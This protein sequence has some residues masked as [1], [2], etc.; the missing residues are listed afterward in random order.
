[1]KHVSMTIY[2]IYILL[3]FRSCLAQTYPLWGKLKPGPNGV[4]F[5]LI[6]VY[7]YSRFFN[8]ND[9]LPVHE[10]ISESARPIRVYLWYPAQK[11][12]VS[13]LSFQSFLRMAA[14]N[15]HPLDS[16]IEDDLE[17]LP[18]PVQLEKG[19]N[20]ESLKQLIS[21]TTASVQNAA[22]Q[23]GLF[24]LIVFGQGLYYESPLTHLV[25]CEYLASHGY[26]VATCPLM[27]THY[28]LVNLNVV[29]LETQ[30]RDMEF[31]ISRARALPFVHPH[32]LGVIGYDMGGMAG[33]TLSMRNPEV[34]AFVSLDAGI[35]F[36]HPSALPNNHP[37]YS[38]EKFQ[39]P[40]MHMT[41]ARFLSFARSQGAVSSS[42][43]RKQYGDSYLFLVNTESHGDFTSYSM[44]GIEN[45]V[46]AY[47]GP[48]EKDPQPLYEAI[49]RYCLFFLDGYIKGNQKSLSRLQEN[50][51]DHGL[52]DI[53]VAIERKKGDEPP[54][55]KDDLVN[56]IIRQGTAEAMP[57][58][59]KFRA[60]Y[61]DSLLF[62]ENVLNWLGYHFLYWWGREKE[63]IEVFKLNTEAF[64]ESAN[65]YDSLGEA[66]V[67]D[68]QTDLAI[69]NYK[70]SLELNPDNNNAK[71]ILRRLE[72]EK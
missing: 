18:K 23:P 60:A 4:G 26:V 57:I 56:L 28:R 46:T 6:K 25:L 27:G 13:G 72:Q 44:F 37:H 58:L 69:E 32:R 61:P 42:M 1:M 20:N 66:Y 15:F 9:L 35:L 55:S 71:N 5:Q 65:A 21:K 19:L 31:A 47:W 48:I 63:A 49:C 59:L 68:G 16:H 14:E 11:K 43:D 64:P 34:D 39:I 3:G 24:P 8:T 52:D 41:Q 10:N 51:Q 30:I 54:P 33:M 38:E 29:D 62:D 12:T 67:N 2:L 22:P 17:R 45:P 40:W 50:H 36:G 53:F 7:D 70:K